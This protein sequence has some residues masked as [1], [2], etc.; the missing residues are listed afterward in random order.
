MHYYELH[1]FTKAQAL[2]AAETVLCLI[3]NRRFFLHNAGEWNT[4]R[5][6][7]YTLHPE[8]FADAIA[9]NE[10]HIAAHR[11]ARQQAQDAIQQFEA[12]NRIVPAD[13]PRGESIVEYSRYTGG[14]DICRV[15]PLAAFAEF[16]PESLE[17]LTAKLFQYRMGE[18]TADD[19]A[20]KV[21]R[22][23]QKGAEELATTIWK[24]LQAIDA[25]NP[26]NNRCMVLMQS[27]ISM[28][29][30]DEKNDFAQGRLWDMQDFPFAVGF[31]LYEYSKKQRIVQHDHVVC[32]TSRKSHV[33]FAHWA[34]S[35][36]AKG[37]ASI[38]Y[39]A[40]EGYSSKAM[41]ATVL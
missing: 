7:D 30:R 40:T 5:E 11:E 38:N 37:Q 41:F 1:P 9:L 13:V 17:A 18:Q 23:Y 29:G 24:Q 35:S 26:N 36:D 33:R 19:V 6:E 16:V 2:H 15:Y 27:R 31:L 25:G 22:S 10:A 39:F 12:D 3:R 34:Q 32:S 8:V 20:P 14:F 21:V 4:Y 28:S